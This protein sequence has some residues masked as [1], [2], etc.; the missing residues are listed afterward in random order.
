MYSMPQSDE[1]QIHEFK[2]SL[3]NGN[4]IRSAVLSPGYETTGHV[5]AVILEDQA[6]TVR[7]YHFGKAEGDAVQDTKIPGLTGANSL[8]FSPQLPELSIAPLRSYTVDSYAF[9][10][11]RVRS[12]KLTDPVSLTYGRN[13]SL[14]A[15][16]GLDGT[17]RIWDLATYERPEVLY[18]VRLEKQPVTALKFGEI[19]AAYGNDPPEVTLFAVTVHGRCY[20]LTFGKTSLSRNWSTPS[21]GEF[22]KPDGRI[23]IEWN[24]RCIATHPYHPIFAFGGD[25]GVVWTLDYRLNYLSMLK[26]SMTETIKHLEFLPE[27]KQLAVVGDKEVQLWAVREQT[28]SNL[29]QAGNRYSLV[30]RSSYK[31][32]S[33]STA[34]QPS[35]EGMT[36]LTALSCGSSLCIVW[37]HDQ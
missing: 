16:S 24:C 21:D 15:A 14:L 7:A 22:L 32:V 23:P 25:E 6:R 11:G 5:L 29:A 10:L 3:E 19:K 17:I 35:T 26:T 9:G 36:A 28:F 12:L 37:S 27:A 33:L 4:K 34:V 13:G 18:E 8:V 31:P 2:I 1:P 30:G 20:Q